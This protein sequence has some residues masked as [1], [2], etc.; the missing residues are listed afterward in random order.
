MGLQCSPKL[1]W[2][3]PCDLN[4]H[5]V[6]DFS[7]YWQRGRE[8]I[9]TWKAW[10]H[11]H[12]EEISLIALAAIHN[13][14]IVVV[15]TCSGYYII[16]TA[17]GQL[18]VKH[19]EDDLREVLLELGCGEPWFLHHTSSGTHFNP[20]TRPY[21]PKSLASSYAFLS[22][23]KEPQSLVSKLPVGVL[24][25]IT[26]FARQKSFF[27]EGWDKLRELQALDP[28][29]DAGDYYDGEHWDVDGMESDLKLLAATKP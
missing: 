13:K 3:V 28:D 4:A 5:T 1:A 23:A 2:N 25:V 10:G 6:G 29:V 19:G 26:S 22:G 27:I 9:S 8:I 21:T 15:S 12:A 16:Y 7:E 11:G 24:K 18:Y 20:T 17:H 14:A